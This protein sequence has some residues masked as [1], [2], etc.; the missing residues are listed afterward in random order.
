MIHY[1][2]G[3]ITNFYNIVKRWIED[4]KKIISHF[5]SFLYSIKLKLINLLLQKLVTIVL[6]AV[7]HVLITCG[8]V[9]E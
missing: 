2:I 1:L 7:L 3:Y 8:F 6:I 9:T 5:Q 4:R